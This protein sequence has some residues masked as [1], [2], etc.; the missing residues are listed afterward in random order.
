MPKK[1]ATGDTRFLAYL[2]TSTEELQDPEES[3]RWQ[4]ARAKA[5]VAGHGEI[6]VVAHDIGQSRSLPWRRRPEAAAILAEAAR[7]DRRFDAIVVAEPQRAFAGSE[8]ANVFPTLTH[9]GVELWVPE[10]GG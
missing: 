2:R 7:K 8:F 1:I 3:K 9:Y 10:V 4:L 5:L 6:V